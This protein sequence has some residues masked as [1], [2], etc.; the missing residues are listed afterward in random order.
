MTLA[1]AGIA[2]VMIPCPVRDPS[3]YGSALGA[4][5]ARAG[6]FYCQISSVCRSAYEDGQEQPTVRVAG[7]GLRLLM[8]QPWNMESRDIDALPRWYDFGWGPAQLQVSD[9][10]PI[11]VCAVVGDEAVLR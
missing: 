8:M 2:A 11:G 6:E 3:D 10:L 4:D 1:A 7:E 9:D 5:W